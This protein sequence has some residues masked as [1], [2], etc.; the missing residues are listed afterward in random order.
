MLRIVEES[1]FVGSECRFPFKPLSWRSLLQVAFLSA[2]R[3]VE[4][5]SVRSC[6]L[7]YKTVDLSVVL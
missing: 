4:R 3:F 6:M 7:M 5:D 1:S 2:P